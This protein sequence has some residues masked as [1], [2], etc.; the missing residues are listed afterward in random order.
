[1]NH[2]QYRLAIFSNGKDKHVY[3][4]A[5]NPAKNK[6]QRVKI[7]LNGNKNKS[8]RDRKIEAQN[9]IK[10]INAKLLSG[11]NPFINEDDTRKYVT[12][13]EALQKMM[14]DKSRDLRPASIRAYNFYISKIHAYLEKKN[15]PEMWVVSF[16]KMDAIRLVEMLSSKSDYSARS[17]NSAIGVLKTFWSWLI[18]KGYSEKNPFLPLKTR[19]LP[20][21]NRIIIPESE[22]ILMEKY[23]QRHD[24]PF[25]MVCKLLFSC[26]IRPKEITFLK[27][28]HFDFET[29]TIYISS[30]FA[31][32]KSNRIVTIPKDLADELQCYFK[33]HSCQRDEFIF[34]HGK[35]FLPSKK[36]A[37]SQK[38]R[39]HWDKM[40]RALELPETYKFY[41][42]KDTG[43]VELLNSGVPPQD[44]V[45]QARLS[46]LQMLSIYAIHVDQNVIEQ[47]L[48]KGKSF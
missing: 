9:I 31:K 22:R 16:S 44:V 26:F 18:E 24:E 38:F 25:L 46:G 33:H 39:I 14:K 2:L 8:S 10:S 45:R 40:R 32:N 35:K 5:L 7:R 4:Y 36:Q 1:M 13:K 11:W 20:P 48:D 34:G 21:K 37:N 42:L 28:R 15:E 19:K 41:S 23:L 17:Y 43:I 12:L 27:R 30:S 6:L 29:S 3:Y 47:I